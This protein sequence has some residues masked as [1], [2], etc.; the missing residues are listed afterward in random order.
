MTDTAYGKPFLYIDGE[1][2]EGG[3]RQHQDIINPANG[4]ATAP[5][6]ANNYAAQLGYE[7]SAMAVSPINGLLYM[8]ERT[9]STLPR[10]MRPSRMRAS[11]SSRLWQITAGP[12]KVMR[13]ASVPP[14]RAM[15]EPG[16]RLPRTN[17]S[18][19]LDETGLSSDWMMPPAGTA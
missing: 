10:A 9:T 1:F 3:D 11:A 12:W 17:T 7:S 8:I 13:R 5:A 4:A 6:V 2:I 19:G 16:S 18:E 14:M 15:P